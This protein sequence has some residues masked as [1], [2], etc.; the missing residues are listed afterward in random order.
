[1]V[2]NVERDSARGRRRKGKNNEIVV[3]AANTVR[4]GISMDEK[5]VEAE[6]RK[7]V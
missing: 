1:M 6:G 3:E 7:L 2:E 5:E 4:R